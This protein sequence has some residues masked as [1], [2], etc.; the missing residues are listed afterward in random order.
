VGH[1]DAGCA[2]EAEGHYTA[3]SDNLRAGVVGGDEVVNSPHM[4]IELCLVLREKLE[5]SF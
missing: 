3:F 4:S 5:F 2:T 1:T